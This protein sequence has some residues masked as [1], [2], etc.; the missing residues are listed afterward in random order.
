MTVACVHDSNIR[1]YCPSLN[2][3]LSSESQSRINALE[4]SILFEMIIPKNTIKF[5]N[6]YILT[7]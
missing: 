1:K 3:S 5:P 4:N 7:L 6:T 2:E